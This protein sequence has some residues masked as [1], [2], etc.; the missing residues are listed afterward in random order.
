M[1]IS[2]SRMSP[3]DIFVFVDLL[4]DGLPCWGH[5]KLGATDGGSLRE[6]FWREG[7]TQNGV[8]GLK[9]GMSPELHNELIAT[10][11]ATLG[12]HDTHAARESFFPNCHHFVM[13]RR[14]KVRLAVSWWKLVKTQQGHI[15]PGEAQVALSDDDYSYRAIKH[16]IGECREREDAIWSQLSKWQV[17]PEVIV[18]EDIAATFQATVR[19]VMDVLNL[20]YSSIVIPEPAFE[21]TADVLC[22]RRVERFHEQD[23]AS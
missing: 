8:L 21:R 11:C 6:A 7:T 3:L 1:E 13:T 2:A 22:E 19:R 23:G 16:L 17:T 18:Y 12:T 14:D 20:D 9:Y 5:G 15:K 4:T 10:M